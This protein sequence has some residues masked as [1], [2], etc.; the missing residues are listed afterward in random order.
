MSKG[1][2]CL[3]G[4]SHGALILKSIKKKKKKSHNLSGYWRHP[5]VEDQI[6]N[7]DRV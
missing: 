2:G 1:K 3:V 5:K 7:E 4:Y 6:L